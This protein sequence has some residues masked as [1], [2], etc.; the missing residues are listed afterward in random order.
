MNED[1]SRLINLVA[2]CSDYCATIEN[3]PSMGLSDLVYSLLGYLPRIYFEFHDL[4]VPEDATFDSWGNNA[5][6]EH[7]DEQ[8]YDAIRSQLA[9]AFGEHDTYLE[10]FEKDM[11]YS[12]TPIASTISENL[13][14]IF[15]PLYNFI[16]ET[17][18]S[19][20]NNIEEAFR[21]CSE[22]FSD[23]WSQILCNV[24]RALNAIQSDI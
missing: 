12:D 3:A 1:N 7:L 22:A 24:L 11:K 5:L 13:A 8:Y 17:R 2:L 4:P 10:T 18:E 23:Y 9:V 20:G 14:D 21:E 15:Q 6:S 19:E 16:M